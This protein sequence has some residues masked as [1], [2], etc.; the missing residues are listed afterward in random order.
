MGIQRRSFLYSSATL[1]GVG[2]LGS[3][4][5]HADE[6]PVLHAR[7]APLM[8][9]CA[10]R[11]I[12]ALDADQRRR[13]VFSFDA[14][15]RMNWQ[16]IPKQR[17]GLPFKE[18]KTYQKDLS[19]ALLAS[20]LSQA[21]YI[22]AVTIMS[23]EDVLSLMEGGGGE[24]RD[25]E[26]Y[27]FSIFG[28]PSD[29]GTWGYRVEGHHFSQNYTVV[30]GQVIDGP[31]FFGANP[32]EVRQG[33]RKGLRTLPREDDLGIELLHALDEQQQKLAIV[34]RSAY[35]DIL[36]AASRK[37]ALQ[38]QPSGLIASS[39]NDRQVDVLMAL[40]GEYARNVPSDLSEGRIAQMNRAGR[41]VYFAWS[42]GTNPGD[43]HY[44]RIQT[45]YF[46]IELDNTQ[47]GANHIHCV[48]R[49]FNGDFGADLLHRHYQ[50]SNHLPGTASM[51]AGASFTG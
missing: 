15:E 26:K 19:S 47:N 32:A 38:G 48:W 44:Y 10:R 1:L 35:D 9:E 18:M 22:K 49:D 41:N 45:P 11:L 7:T 51:R 30:N 25:P 27:Y 37:A 43:P 13:T 3:Q 5:G 20:G 34:D 4:K 16:Y 21:G 33:P 31:S 17:K 36:T 14:D 46:L 23:L 40:V 6:S 50:T 28:N 8:A 24:A 42:G 12:A 2:M 39:M 29:T